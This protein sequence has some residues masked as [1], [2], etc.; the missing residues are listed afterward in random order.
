MAGTVENMIQIFNSI[1]PGKKISFAISLIIVMGGFAAILMYTNRPDYQ[2]LFA[3][4]DSGDAAKISD[5]LNGKQIQYQ[6]SDGGSTILVPSDKVYQLR[7][8]L[9]SEGIPAGGTVGFEVFDDI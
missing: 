2:V 5:Q 6:L 9:A 3:N 1:P 7:L 4:L 8:E